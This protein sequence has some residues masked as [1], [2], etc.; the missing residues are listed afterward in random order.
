MAESERLSHEENVPGETGRQEQS[1]PKPVPPS[2]REQTPVPDTTEA[3]RDAT[4]AEDPGGQRG[5]DDELA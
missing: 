1:S 4:P 5:G 3:E 2:Q